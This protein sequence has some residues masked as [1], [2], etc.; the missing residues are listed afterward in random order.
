MDNKIKKLQKKINIKFKN[1]NLI[2]KAITHK[3]FDE[4]NNFEK[5]EFLGDRILGLVISIN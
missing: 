4:E 3:S 2:K 1:I 5:L